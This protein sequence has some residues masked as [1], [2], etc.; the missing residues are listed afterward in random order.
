M[1]LIPWTSLLEDFKITMFRVFKEIRKQITS[2][3]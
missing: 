2:I 1:K 3:F